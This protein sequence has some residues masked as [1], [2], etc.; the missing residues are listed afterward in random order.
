MILLVVRE[1]PGSW[2]LDESRGCFN[3]GS[4]GPTPYHSSW[5]SSAAK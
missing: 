3:N 1:A 2:R 5:E 4:F